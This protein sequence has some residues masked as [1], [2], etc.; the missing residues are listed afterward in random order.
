[1]RIAVVGV[2]AALAMTLTS[3]AVWS[4]TEPSET[5]ERS[6][7]PGADATDPSKRKG[8]KVENDPI[9]PPKLVDKST[10]V[11]GKTL[12]V[13]GRLGHARML[14]N[15]Q[16]ETYVFVNVR[17]EV[18]SAQLG[19]GGTGTAFEPLNLAIVIDRSGSMV[20]QRERNAIDAAAGMIRRL[21]D[22]DTVSVVSYSNE[23]RIVLPVTTVSTA[24]HEQLI[25]S[26]IDNMSD[27][28]DGSTCISC[29]IDLGMRTL[30]GRRAGLD[31]MLLLSDGEAN[32][33][34][35]DEPGIRSLARQA[36]NQG[37]TISS[38]G[39]DI[40]YNER[41][42]SAL[43]REANGHHYFSETGSN[44]EQI[45]DQEL[46][47]LVKT[48]AKD[49]RLEVE[50]APGVRVAE[51]FDRAYQQVDR[52][53]IVPLGNFT[54]GEDKTF[55]M[56][57]EVP[58]SPAGE[59]P[60]ANVTLSYQDLALREPGECF[61]ELAMQMATSAS[62]VAQ[63]DAIV[64]GRLSRAET[65][66]TLEQANLLFAQG[67]TAE[68]QATVDAHL[69]NLEA[70]RKTATTLS[71]AKD[72]FDPFNRNLDDDFAE[73]DVALDEAAAGFE[74]AAAAPEPTAAPAGRSQVRKNAEKA[75]A[76]AL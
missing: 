37:A 34:V 43:A 42:M 41:L 68:A 18:D 71:K 29:G 9:D 36:R 62:E 6:A 12:M 60:I 32:R 13:E 65:V 28:P 44:L 56:R 33:G 8:P 47:S 75:D 24:T 70:Q 49:G 46:E 21:R 27:K 16:S 74:A 2:L 55:L 54:P 48:V 72:F 52:K 10:F 50:L 23:A 64:L 35:T 66:R 1:M 40:D 59:R 73:Q 11:T 58:P 51:V 57:L 3:S 4:M 67:R 38:I 31:R 39:V 17:S 5:A 20:G 53:V 7:K 76:L 61:G 45:F 25:R 14:A 22:G 69:K 30:V 63:L 19:I 15:A 26:M